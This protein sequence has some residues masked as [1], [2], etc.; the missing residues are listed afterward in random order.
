MSVRH[1]Y[2]DII[3]RLHDVNYNCIA[4][5]AAEYGRKDI[6]MYAINKG[7]TNYN[8]VALAS[9]YWNYID[10]VESMLN[11]GADKYYEIIR[12]AAYNGYIDL[13]NVTLKY[14]KGECIRN[15]RLEN[16]LDNKII[17]H[18]LC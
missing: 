17:C 1:G 5:E 2:L 13:V 4:K 11:K 16:K 9:V 8:D 12:I 14:I 6:L 18:I 7:I 3:E 15:K 10:V